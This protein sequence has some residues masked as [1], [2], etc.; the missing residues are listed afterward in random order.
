LIRLPVAAFA[1][2]VVA[3]IGAFFVTQHLKVSNP[4]I[5]GS[6]RPDPPAINPIDGR[7][8]RDLAG[9]LASF[10]KTRLSFFLQS[11]S[12][13]VGVYMVDSQGELVSTLAGSRYMRVGRRSTFTWNGREGNGDGPVAPDGTYF[14]RVALQHENRTFTLSN[15]PV[16]VITTPPHPRITRVVRTGGSAG[17]G[18]AIITGGQSATI[19]FTPAPYKSTRIL[20]YR[21]DLPGRPRL[22]FSF[23]A[24]G[25]SGQAVW[26]GLVRGRPAPAGTYLVGMSVT[27][28]ACNRASYPVVVPPSPGSTPHAG[29]TVRYLAAEPPLVPVPSGSDATVLVDARGHAYSWAL[30]RFGT[31]KLL[32]RGREPAGHYTLR[33][34][35]P[36]GR[37]ALYAVSLQSGDHRT[38]VPLV[39]SASGKAAF[40]RVLVVLP[41]L[42]WE[43]SDPV[44]DTGSGIPT[45]LSAGDRIA[46]DRPL[47]NGLPADFPSELALVSYLNRRHLYYQL[48]TDLGLADGIGPHLAGH[49]GVVLDGSLAWL[50]SSLTSQLSTFARSGGSVVSVGVNTLQSQARISGS[51]GNQ[52]AG[53]PSRLPADPFGADHGAVSGLK[54]ALITVLSD[55]LRIF[56]TAIAFP[57]FTVGQAITPPRGTPGA[58]VSAAGVAT[59]QPLI[60]GFRDG[61]GKVVEIGLPQFASAL[62]HNVGA[63]ELFGRLWNLLSR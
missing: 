59:G 19:H 13:N 44:D 5:N 2:L 22:V 27:D 46:V 62:P 17:A 20:I 36:S 55:R 49:A 48:T 10:K 54:G 16:H 45:T 61:R 9:K 52:T 15:I 4:L 11:R 28:Q 25:R 43:G 53:P 31:R 40:T 63:Q 14:F 7:V 8:C 42:S 41:A 39:S 6:P 26:N 1:A 33:V 58:A 30:R 34:R 60:T 35:L 32:T 51:P 37:A 24:K 12:D 56:G 18:P 38:E 50:P 21:T 57:G 23:G 29:V 47:V 3:T